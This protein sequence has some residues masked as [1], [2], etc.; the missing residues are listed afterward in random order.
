M[1]INFPSSFTRFVS[2]ARLFAAAAA[3]VAVSAQAASA[4]PVTLQYS[5]TGDGTIAK[6]NT[7]LGTLLGIDIS[8]DSGVSAI[9]PLSDGGTGIGTCIGSFSG[10]SYTVSAPG[11]GPTLLS[12]TGDGNVNF[13][14]AQFEVAL[15]RHAAASL[16]SSL[17]GTFSSAGV[18]PI[19]LV[20]SI[21][22]GFVLVVRGA[23]SSGA[24]TLW[25][26]RLTS[27]T[28]TYTYCAVGDTCTADPPLP[29]IPEPATLTM[30]AFGLA[31]VAGSRRKRRS[32]S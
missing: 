9:N 25:D 31:S 23:G 6:F 30:L 3:L 14:C 2:R 17:F 16:D 24:S 27:G 29:T 21:V 1:T 10:G 13:P 22:G 18:S 20:Q 7:N 12:L 26:P 11:G 5:Y 19:T 32:G 28:V 8:L 4:A 15:T